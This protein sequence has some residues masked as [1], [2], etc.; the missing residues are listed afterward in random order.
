[1]LKRCEP[2]RDYKRPSGI[3]VPSHCDL[4]AFVTTPS[5]ATMADV[6]ADRLAEVERQGDM[7]KD[8]L[9]SEEEDNQAITA[10]S[11]GNDILGNLQ[12]KEAAITIPMCGSDAD[13]LTELLAAVLSHNG[14]SPE[15]AFPLFDLNQDGKISVSDLLQSCKQVNIIAS[16]QQV[17]S[18][19]AQRAPQDDKSFL[20]VDAWQVALFDRVFKDYSHSHSMSLEFEFDAQNK[21][22]AAHLKDADR[23]LHKDSASDMPSDTP[24]EDDDEKKSPIPADHHLPTRGGGFD[25]DWG[26][27]RRLQGEVRHELVPQFEHKKKE[28]T[29][30]QHKQKRGDPS[31][32]ASTTPLCWPSTFC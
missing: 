22:L 5:I 31:V 13:D 17:A 29:H 1:M 4:N 26:K 16:E 24:S 8:L 15:E 20:T 7:M 11:A 27:G 21:L 6:F 18:W 19:I 12:M 10:L 14:S 9:A 23:L 28:E 2:F 30:L 3:R 32:Y 25:S